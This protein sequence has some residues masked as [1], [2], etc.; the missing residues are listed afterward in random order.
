MATE[1]VPHSSL[2]EPIRYRFTVDEFH[3]MVEAGILAED[4]RIELIE[5]DITQMSPVGGPHA[6]CVDALTR[7]FASLAGTDA[8]LRVQNAV[9]LSDDTELQPDIS[10]VTERTYGNELPG[11]A[12]VLLLIEVAASTFATDRDI[13]VPL[14]ARYEVPQTILIDVRNRHLWHFSEPREYGYQVV[15]RYGGSDQLKIELTAALSIAF[16]VTDLFVA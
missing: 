4:D 12:D 14:Y 2:I 15:R 8:R 1:T 10:I 13:K 16:R 9:R 6:N 11:A 3:R 7:L 5:G